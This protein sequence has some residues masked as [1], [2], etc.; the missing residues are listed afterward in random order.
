MAVRSARVSNRWLRRQ[1]ELVDA[2]DPPMRNHSDAAL[3]ALLED[4]RAVFVRG[5]QDEEVVRRGFAAVREAARRETGESAYIVQLMGAMA[6]YHGRVVQMLT[7]EGKTLTGSIA[8]PLLAWEHKHLHVLTVNDYLAKRDAESRAAIFARCGLRCG[9]IQQEQEPAERFGIYALPIVYG[10]PKQITA[11]Y[12]RDQIRMGQL[13]SAWSGRGML[14]QEGVG[15]HS[16]GPMVPGLRAGMVDEADAVLIDE[17]VVP[18]I[19]ARS[20]GQDE[21]ADVYKQ[22]ALIAAGLD[23]RTDFTVDFL[24][25][26]ADL[27][28]RGRERAIAL[29]EGLSEPIWR[30]HR[31]AEEL[32]RTALAARMCYHNGRQFQIVDGR[33]MIV[34]E[35][36]GRFLLDRTWEHGLHQAVEAK[37]GLD[38]TAD[39]ETLARMSFQRF[40]RSYRILSGMTGTAADATGEIE[41]VY[42]R[43]VMV[44]PTH[45]PIARRLLPARIFRTSEARWA[46][47][48]ESIAQIH[49][50][51]RPI[52]VGARSITASEMLAGK[53][54]AR[55][56]PHHVLNANFDKEE[57]AI[58]SRAGEAGSIVVA[59]NMA[60][61]GT[62]IKLDLK[63]RRA[64]G[65]HVI[66]TEM[67]GA[68]RI[69]RQF[70]GRAGRQGDPGSAQFFM[71]LE[72]EL[73]RLQAGLLG[74][75]LRLL[76]AGSEEITG[77]GRTLALALFRLA[78]RAGE[79][80]DR[81]MRAQVMKQDDWVDK[82]LPGM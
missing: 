42:A 68:Q 69:D 72:D 32:I 9:A 41:S 3:A 17:G 71:S 4:L 66:L 11:D 56:L 43:K 27:T 60:G 74:G 18:L 44:I 63:A 47:V 73:I 45:R 24:R 40:F 5:R 62:D 75:A 14:G 65:L 52:L 67:H 8:A 30:A 21:M 35:Y 37:E 29:A 77:A 31:R 57:A 82:H 36:T 76:S 22:A 53:L 51:G 58:I 46:A 15:G 25:R 50:Q 16:S 78:Q 19:I 55:A 7:G 26:R 59:T 64:G 54:T 49:A 28:R 38:I 34:D 6:L 12:L 81:A 1:A 2:L 20:R 39:R 70:I 13:T 10:T 61:R 48:V 79:A 80:R 33:V 23:P